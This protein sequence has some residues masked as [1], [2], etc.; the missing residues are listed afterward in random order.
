MVQRL[1]PRVVCV[2]TR[3]C[4]PLHPLALSE[5]LMKQRT[6]G[7]AASQ[8]WGAQGGGPGLT[9]RICA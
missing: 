6:N 5:V 9:F 1:Q 4:M 3:V 2:F 7:L 8:V